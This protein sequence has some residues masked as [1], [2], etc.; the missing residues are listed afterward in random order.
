MTQFEI[1]MLDAQ[2]RLINI[3][4][5]RNKI[6]KEAFGIYFGSVPNLEQLVKEIINIKK[7]LE[8]GI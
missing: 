6:L 4:E 8:D 5:K 2:E 3:Q 7:T 1:K